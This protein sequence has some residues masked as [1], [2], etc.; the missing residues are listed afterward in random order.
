MNISV[1]ALGYSF[2]AI[3]PNQEI[4]N[5]WRIIAA[6][7]WCT[8]YGTWLDFAILVKKEDRKW[9]SDI[10]RLFIYLPSIFFFIGNLL[11]K[12]EVVIQ[13]FGYVWKD[14]YPV[15]YFEILFSVYSITFSIAGI[16]IIYKWGMNSKSKRE[17]KQAKIIVITALISFVLATSTDIILPAIGVT[18]FPLGI[19]LLTIALVG[20]YHAITK[21]KMMS[22]SSQVA[23][24]Y[25]LKTISDPVILIGNDL[26]IKIANSAALEL[27]SFDEKELVGRS[28]SK[29]IADTD[30]NQALIQKLVKTGFI[31]NIEVGLLTKEKNSIP[32]LLSG[33]TI[34]NEMDDILGIACIFHDITDR[35]N[36]ENFLLN[37]HNELE[38][39][40]RERTNELQEINTLLEE[41]INERINAE[42]SLISS[43]EKFRA[44]MK[45][46]TDGILVIDKETRKL[47]ES[48]E[49]AHKILGL[50]EQQLSELVNEPFNP[51]LDNVIKFT[52]NKM[53]DDDAIKLL[54][55]TIN[56]TQSNGE[57]MYLKFVASHV[58]YHN[59]QF[60]MIKIRD[61]TDEVIMEGRKQQMAKMEA[62]G[63]LSG[64]IAHDFNNIL[65]GIMGYT[66]LTLD[67]LEPES[68]TSDNLN[69][70][71]KLGERA[72]KLI[73]QILSFSKK[74]L[75]KPDYVDIRAIIEDVIKMLR[76]TLP[77]N[78]DIEFNLG[79]D[80][81]IVYADQGE[82]HQLIMNLCVNAELAM[83]KVG[84][85]LQVYLS[86]VSIN[87]NVDIGY[88]R[89]KS[90]NYIKLE[91]IDHGCGMDDAIE[92][93][94]FEPFFTTRSDQG[95]TG[96][97]LSV[98]HGIVS[99]CEG[100]IIVD[101]EPDK[102]STFT[103]FFPEASDNYCGKNSLDR[104]KGSGNFHILFVDDEESI[105]KTVQKLLHRQ[106]YE[107]TGVSNAREALEV[108]RE[109]EDLIDI[110]IT[111]QSMPDLS[112]DAL[113]QEMRIIR[114]KLPAVICSGYLHNHN[115]EE[116]N[117]TEFLL[118]PVSID[119][120]VMV[121]DKLLHSKEPNLEH[122]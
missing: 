122:N 107:V 74:S 120:Y 109:K 3:A 71:L 4:A 101:S 105:V 91:V 36:T 57:S 67:E 17:K 48:N 51:S 63:T 73:L 34:K 9:M 43:E 110:V 87:E 5:H 14:S 19:I 88:Q 68:I 2:M 89:L 12:P 59:K 29:F 1:W 62:L 39:M 96:L 117:N 31:N 79:E 93:R 40:V 41:E 99:R 26:L 25:V 69:E 90:G 78:I 7:G 54:K 32:C 81:V 23:N 119:E 53:I 95:G 58:G 102:G 52:I 30:N 47:V 82:I 38:R 84:G 66:Q 113:L 24:E 46:A 6:M 97:G 112:G 35:K 15:S 77:V 50:S 49:E 80:S 8:F 116:D 18:T 11:Y 72:K 21:Y 10:R 108:F 121:I 13:R 100:V 106:G 86:K 85:I 55:E 65:A 94:I 28:I 98:V 92:K 64:G 45:Q 60:S 118:K 16:F 27:T 20:I 114:P 61:I 104:I 70:V 76:A 115:Y 42:E 83:D 75:L 44:L 33:S 103:V 111:D 56:Y 37:A 22:L